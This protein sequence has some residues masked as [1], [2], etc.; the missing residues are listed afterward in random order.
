[1]SPVLTIIRL[2]FSPSRSLSRLFL[3]SPIPLTLSSGVQ[4]TCTRSAVGYNPA[5]A[6]ERTLDVRASNAAERTSTSL[7]NAMVLHPIACAV[8]FLAFLLCC[9]AGVIGSLVGF[10]VAGLAWVLA[11]VGMA[12][13]FAIFGVSCAP[14][15]LAALHFTFSHFSPI[16]LPS[17]PP[18]S[19]PTHRDTRRAV[20]TLP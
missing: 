18:L 17:G 3:P 19:S 5:Q 7:T 6:I 1:M 12:I 10:V 9:G 4:D 8:A 20:L 13:D 11:L 16:P 2:H 15:R 14:F